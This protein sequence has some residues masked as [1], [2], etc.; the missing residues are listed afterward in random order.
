MSEKTTRETICDA[1]VAFVAECRQSPKLSANLDIAKSPGACAL[2]AALDR[3]EFAQRDEAT[4]ALSRELAEAAAQ[5]Q[6]IAARL[7]APLTADEAAKMAGK[8]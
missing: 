7:N 4:A 8:G 2:I 5:A 6:L 1:I 3:H